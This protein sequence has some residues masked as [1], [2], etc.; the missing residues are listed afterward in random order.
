[1]QNGKTQQ[2][3][4]A[5]ATDRLTGMPVLIHLVPQH[6]PLPILPVHS[7]LLPAIE[8]DE[9]DSPSGRLFYVVTELPFQAQQATDVAFVAK[10]ALNAL[11]ALHDQGLTHGNISSSQ[12]WRVGGHIALAGAGLPWH[13]QASTPTD[14]LYSLFKTLEDLGGLPQQLAHLY[15]NLADL[16]AL[17]VLA[18]LEEHLKEHLKEVEAPTLVL[19][20]AQKSAAKTTQHKAKLYKAELLKSSQ[21][22]AELLFS[23]LPPDQQEVALPDLPFALTQPLHKEETIMSNATVVKAKSAA[24]ALLP[25]SELSLSELDSGHLLSQ[26]S[27]QPSIQ[28][29]LPDDLPEWNPQD[30]QEESLNADTQDAPE[31]R[32]LKPWQ[33]APPVERIPLSLQQAEEEQ[34]REQ[35][36]QANEDALTGLPR[37]WQTN[38]VERLPL[39]LRRPVEDLRI[40]IVLPEPIKRPAGYIPPRQVERAPLKIGWEEDDSWRVVKE[41]EVEPK[42][43]G[44]NIGRLFLL[45][46][47]VVLVMVGVLFLF[48]GI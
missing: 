41:L 47:L 26:S 30:A 8:L 18:H 21:L 33:T 34:Q 44:L 22:Q 13:T 40:K 14:D 42:P 29:D 43:T 3:S 23:T 7:N 11:I 10:D 6:T 32:V 45:I 15:S 38:E 39:S 17:E 1:M 31:P 12:L 9:A 27:I 24:Q 4:T 37:P 2:I 20:G 19:A 36:E 48:K 16:S 46:G 28:I 35:Q 5:W 25:L